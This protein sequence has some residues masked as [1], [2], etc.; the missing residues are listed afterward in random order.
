MHWQHPWCVGT[1]GS[2]PPSRR[3]HRRAKILEFALAAG[4]LDEPRGPVSQV[5]RRRRGGGG[6]GALVQFPR[7]RC[8]LLGRDSLAVGPVQRTR[9]LPGAKEVVPPVLEEGGGV[10]S[11]PARTKEGAGRA[12][13]GSADERT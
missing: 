5:P 4:G 8:G 9:L 11:C 1:R 3:R 12:G 10:V 6:L 7:G 2:R 13:P